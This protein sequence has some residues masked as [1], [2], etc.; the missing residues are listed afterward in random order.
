MNGM[1]TRAATA[2][3]MNGGMPHHMMKIGVDGSAGRLMTAL[4]RSVHPVMMRSRRGR[5]RARLLAIWA[6]SLADCPWYLSAGDVVQNG[7]GLFVEM[8]HD[9]VPGFSRAA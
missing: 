8:Y 3:R 1:P 2:R 4:V 7:P 5:C 6:S 9:S